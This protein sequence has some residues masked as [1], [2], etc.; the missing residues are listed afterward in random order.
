[1][2]PEKKAKR[3][4]R[5]SRR[6]EQARETRRRILAAALKLFSI[7]GYAG[8]TIEAIAQEAAKLNGGDG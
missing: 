4:Y 5:S 8:A 2:A 6:Q 7:Y 1:M 3:A